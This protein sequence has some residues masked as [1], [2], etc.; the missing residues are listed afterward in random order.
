[1]NSTTPISDTT[2][3]VAW[4]SS[5]SSDAALD[6]AIHRERAR[7]GTIHIVRVLDDVGP[8]T[9]HG[10]SEREITAA[11][12]ELAATAVRVQKHAP[13]CLV[14]STLVLGVPY[15][16]LLRF[17]RPGSVLAVGTQRRTAARFHYGWSMGA[18]L[19]AAAKGAV[20]IV[21]DM[22]AEAPSGIVV[23][24]DGSPESRAALRVAASEAGL[25]AE[26][27]IVVHAWREP[28][29]MAGQPIL[30]PVA[31]IALEEE[32]RHLLADA[33]SIVSRDHPG[34]EV[35]L[36]SVHGSPHEALQ[37]SAKSAVELVLGSRGLRG[38][39]RVFLGSIS[40]GI[41]LDLVCPTIIVGDLADEPVR[42]TTAG[43]PVG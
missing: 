43:L 41:V 37:R 18:Q 11:R 36:R 23:G 9:D 8:A 28:S 34:V 32:S 38:M 21:P 14:T 13:G 39:R 12:S 40:H 26:E 10:A 16:E 5:S 29:V 20:A 31:I 7:G 35:L 15:D 4:D 33:G 25:R 22:P 24:Y 6:W 3:V 27:L 42:S 17:V 1:M 30:D 19:A 2:T